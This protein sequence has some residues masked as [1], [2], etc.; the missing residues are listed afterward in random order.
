LDNS[1]ICISA[2]PTRTYKWVLIINIYFRLT[3][4]LAYRTI[5]DE[6][7]VKARSSLLYETKT[8]YFYIIVLVLPFLFLM[9]ILIPSYLTK[10]LYK[11]RKSTF[12]VKFRKKFSY[13]INEYREG[14]WY[15]EIVK[16]FLKVF[17]I[18]SLN[19][20]SDYIYIK[21]SLVYI[22]ITIY[23]IFLLKC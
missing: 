9:T 12:E 2:Y 3:S 22:I 8:H 21:S 15:W 13:L 17:I 5:A 20:Y 11:G 7:W 14:I 1:Y 18:V 4:I 19:L 6:K 23:L 16:L 10:E